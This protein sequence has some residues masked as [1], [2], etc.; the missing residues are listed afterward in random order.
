M[1]TCESIRKS[2][3]KPCKK[4]II[5]KKQLETHWKNIGKSCENH[6]KT[7]KTCG[8]LLEHWKILGKC[9]SSHRIPFRIFRFITEVRS[10]SLHP[11]KWWRISWKKLDDVFVGGFCYMIP[12]WWIVDT[13]FPLFE[14]SKKDVLWN[15]WNEALGWCYGLD[16][17]WWRSF[18]QLVGMAI[19]STHQ[20]LFVRQKMIIQISFSLG[21]SGPTNGSVTWKCC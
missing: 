13:I 15:E 19:M 10:S 9:D 18:Y 8:K 16:A 2:L 6:V 20:W 12:W 3:E 1:K 14:F 21:S 4:K 7:G 17:G 11:P 5:V